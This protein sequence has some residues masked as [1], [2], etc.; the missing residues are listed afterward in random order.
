M[1]KKK[2]VWERLYRNDRTDTFDASPNI[3][4]SLPNDYKSTVEDISDN[5]PVILDDAFHI[6]RN[7]LLNKLVID[8]DN[9]IKL[10]E[11]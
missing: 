11:I 3:M 8:S 2:L 6:K 7:G 1:R 5:E 9:N 10:E 4:K